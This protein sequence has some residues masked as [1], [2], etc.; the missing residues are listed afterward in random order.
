MVGIPV[1][2]LV[3]PVTVPAKMFEEPTPVV[4]ICRSYCVTWDPAVQVK[5]ALEPVRALPGVG[6]DMVAG[7]AGMDSV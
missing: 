7:E 3:W 5:V 2:L 6:D 1:M 4:P